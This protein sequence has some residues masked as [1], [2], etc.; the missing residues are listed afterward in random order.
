MKSQA[1]RLI[2]AADFGTSSTEMKDLPEKP[3]PLYV[4]VSTWQ[5]TVTM[6]AGNLLALLTGTVVT[7]NHTICSAM[8]NTVSKF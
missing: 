3:I 2:L 5:G 7:T 6:F 8:K 1:C 4:S